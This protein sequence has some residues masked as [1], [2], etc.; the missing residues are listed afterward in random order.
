MTLDQRARKATAGLNRAVAETPVRVMV[1]APR[2]PVWSMAAGALVAAAVLAVFFV[3]RPEVVAP[4][5]AATTTVVTVATTTPTVPP[6]APATVIVPPPTTSVVTTA[7]TAAAD[8]T[9][10]LISIT[11]PQPGFVSATKTIRFEGVTE[12]G[13]TVSAGRYEADVASDGTWAITLVLGE[14]ETTA[15]FTATDAAGN[16]ATASVV[17]GYQPTTTTKPVEVA[18]F[19][20]NMTWGECAID[21]PY[22]EYYGTG[23]PGSTIT[24]SSPYGGG[25]TKV[26][27][28]GEWYLKVEFPEAPPNK[29]FVVKAIDSYGRKA[30]FEFT[31][32]V[33]G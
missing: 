2:A 21:P 22:D 26:K 30:V 9:P 29:T 1:A 6:T 4:E 20:A 31:S 13:A 16:T 18:A 23:Q 11:F 8:V 28:S 17:V 10:P 33:G 14:G 7:T 27:E 12:P 24:V 25:S 32:R 5:F 19:T 3:S 15:R